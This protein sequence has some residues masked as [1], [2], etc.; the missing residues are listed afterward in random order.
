MRIGVLS[1]THL[2]M[3]GDQKGIDRI[4]MQQFANVDMILHAGDFVELE[5]FDPLIDGKRFIGVAGNMDGHGVRDVMPVKRILD[6][7]G[8]RIGL[9][10]GWG[11]PWGIE[12]RVAGEFEGVDAIVYGHTHNPSCERKGSVLFFNPGSPTDRRFAKFRSVGFLELNETIEGRIV[13]LDS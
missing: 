10:H 5:V 11:S 8:F 13:R 2:T 1:D 3:S 7:E 6:L 4:F 12:D 9:I